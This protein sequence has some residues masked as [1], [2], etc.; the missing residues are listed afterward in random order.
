MEYY[1]HVP[2]TRLTEGLTLCE[3]EDISEITG[4]TPEEIES[5]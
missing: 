3:F 1:T 4:L 5:L 2:P